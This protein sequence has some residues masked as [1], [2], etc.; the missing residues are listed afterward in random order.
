MLKKAREAGVPVTRKTVCLFAALALN[1][2]N[3]N[4]ALEVL[5][6]VTQTNYISVRNL[7][8][9][10]LSDL[11]R[12]DDLFIALR[13]IINRDVPPEM[14]RQEILEETV[15]HIKYNKSTSIV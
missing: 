11:E 7:R 2:N 8:L 1:Q 5:S 14:R 9:M 15:I 12:F 6:L 4:T 13:L 3:P 10:A